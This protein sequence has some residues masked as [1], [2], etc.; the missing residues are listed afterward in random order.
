[1]NI[2]HSMNICILLMYVGLIIRATVP[3]ILYHFTIM[4][5][6]NVQIIGF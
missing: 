1:M 5:I 4:I 6:M 3:F 2:T